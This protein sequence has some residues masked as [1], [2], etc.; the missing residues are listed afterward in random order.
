[1]KLLKLIALSFLP[2]LLF[3][4]LA[5]IAAPPQEAN[6]LFLEYAATTT[7]EFPVRQTNMIGEA[8][9]VLMIF[10]NKPPRPEGY[11]IVGVYVESTNRWYKVRQVTTNATNY[12]REWFK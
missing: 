12:S 1:M 6:D 4:A 10:T 3:A 5:A 9:L 7:P 11:A 2:A 8:R